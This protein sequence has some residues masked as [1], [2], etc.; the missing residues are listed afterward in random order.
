[1]V[2]PTI[3]AR[4]TV[5][6]VA[7]DPGVFSPARSRKTRAWVQRQLGWRAATLPLRVAAQAVLESNSA[8]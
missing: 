4:A 5:R 1:M 3:T 7:L 2:T 6:S 8:E